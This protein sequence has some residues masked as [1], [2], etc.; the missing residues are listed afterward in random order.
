MKPTKITKFF[1]KSS[2][3]DSVHQPKEN[4]HNNIK[5]DVQTENVDVDGCDNVKKHVSETYESNDISLF[6]NLNRS[7]T[8]AE[9]ILLTKK[10]GQLVIKPFVNF[11]H[12]QEV[13]RTHAICEYHLKSVIDAESFLNIFEKKEIPLIKQIDSERAKQVQENRK[14]LIPII[15]CV[16]LCGRE[17]IPLRGHRDF[18]SFNIK[19]EQSNEGNFRAILKYRA[20]G[21]DYLKSVLE[22]PGKR[23]KYTSPGIQNQI[24]EACLS[25]CGA[26]SEFMYGQ[27]Y[28]GASNMAGQF[29]GVQK[30][31]R[32]KYP[33]A[34]Y[35]H[36]SAHSLNLADSSSINLKLI[37]NYCATRWIQRYEALNDFCELIFYVYKALNFISIEWKDSSSTDAN[38]F[39]K[40]IQDSE[41]LVSLYVTKVLF[42]YGLPV[43]KQLQK[44]RIDLKKTVDI[45]ENL[46]QSL[47]NVR[48][49]AENEFKRIIDEAQTMAELIGT[50]I[51]RKRITSKQINRANPQNLKSTEEYYRV[52]VF[53]PYIDNFISQL[54]DRFVNHK[55]VL[56]GF[57]C[58][59]HSEFS[60]EDRN[61]FQHL[62]KLYSP[63]IDRHNVL[64][65]L[66]MWKLKLASSNNKITKIGIEAFLN[67][68]KEIYP[69]IKLL[70][71][72]FVTFPVSTATPE[73][74]FSSLKR[75]KTHLRNTMN[76]VRTLD[77]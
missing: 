24:I 46:I 76:E 28:D 11:K 63:A 71:K 37:R 19:D 6:S 52:T 23:N 8:D 7:L 75:L 41:F 60:D 39:L 1:F 10:L 21:D 65:E 17:K 22:G 9:K 36:C 40:C 44:E 29:K 68:D 27:G 50:S 4:D 25:D 64:A 70:L 66:K 49:D 43:C 35:V 26:N 12:A 51:S 55:N 48:E 56:R 13:F 58:L 74:S 32:D 34:L 42:S 14:R 16:I 73:R 67:C 31:I 20:K 53:L 72:I 57:E 3:S 45:V 38:M 30:I 47:M 61:E 62:I 33:N 18:G 59:F 15:Q 5:H 2:V 54:T 77:I 69:N